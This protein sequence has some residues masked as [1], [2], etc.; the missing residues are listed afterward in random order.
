VRL[1]PKEQE[2]LTVFLAAELARRRRARGL[3]LNHPEA[4]ALIADEVL[5][6]ARDGASY[7][8]TVVHGYLALGPDDVLD[9]VAA[10]V[11]RL[12]VEPLFEDGTRLVVLHDPIGR[13]E[14]PR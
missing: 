1:T 14:P 11:S 3:K 4:V 10:L 8:D 12:E 13:A 2:R 7:E 9:G 5:E 6:K